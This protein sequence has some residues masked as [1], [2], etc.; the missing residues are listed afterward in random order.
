MQTNKIKC[1]SVNAGPSV[2]H[3][4]QQKIQLNVK[5]L[6]WHSQTDFEVFSHFEHQFEHPIW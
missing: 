4:A 5:I 6:L 1:H 2:C 3:F